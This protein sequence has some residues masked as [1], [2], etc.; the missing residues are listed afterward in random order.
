[1]DRAAP[2][3]PNRLYALS[4]RHHPID[5][6]HNLRRKRRN[7]LDTNRSGGPPSQQSTILPFGDKFHS[8]T[9]TRRGRYPCVFILQ[10]SDLTALLVL[11]NHGTSRGKPGIGSSDF[12]LS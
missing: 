6:E 11:A 3:R 5:R 12:V 7:G 2:V 4:A 10:Q 1:M 9:M 8:M